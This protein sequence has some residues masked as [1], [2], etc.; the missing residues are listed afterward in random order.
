M[1]RLLHLDLVVFLA[2]VVLILQCLE[3]VTAVIT[4]GDLG[5]HFRILNGLILFFG[6]QILLISLLLLCRFFRN[7]IGYRL[8]VNR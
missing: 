2:V 4:Y 6:A 1:Q 5:L 7:S 8:A 3:L